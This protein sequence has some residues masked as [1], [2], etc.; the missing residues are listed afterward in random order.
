MFRNLNVVTLLLTIEQCCVLTIVRLGSNVFPTV[1]NVR[2]IIEIIKYSSSYPSLYKWIVRLVRTAFVSVSW[3]QGRWPRGGWTALSRCG[4][5]VSTDVSPSDEY[6]HFTW[7]NFAPAI[8]FIPVRFLNG[9]IMCCCFVLHLFPV[10]V[11]LL[12]PL[13]WCHWVCILSCGC[14]GLF[15]RSSILRIFGM[16]SLKKRLSVSKLHYY[17]VVLHFWLLS[18]AWDSSN[19][20][21]SHF[22]CSYCFDCSFLFGFHSYR[23]ASFMGV[24]FCYY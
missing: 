12:I 14:V 20:F 2:H 16:L 13:H 23:F 15:V 19:S 1:L 9:A 11:F 4:A 3:W 10:P 5:F 6:F 21:K 8:T 7:L 17:F 22:C 18:F 24:Y